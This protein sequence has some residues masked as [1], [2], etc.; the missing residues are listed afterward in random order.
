[1][2]Y[3]VNIVAIIGI[4]VL[5]IFAINFKNS[6]GEL[7]FSANF[8]SFSREVSKFLKIQHQNI[9]MGLKPPRKAKL[10]YIDKESMLR[11][12]VPDVFGKFSD[13]EWNR[14]WS[15]IYKPI[16]VRQGRYTVKR[17]R[18][19]EEIQKYLTDYYPN[20]FGMFSENNWDDFWG[21]LNIK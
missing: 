10:T 17:Q 9:M 21:M 19:R 4:F 6:S 7:P 3:I 15:V 2:K 14:F 20:P 1:M 18:T 16:E 5:V 13:T 11:E 12:Y 8:R